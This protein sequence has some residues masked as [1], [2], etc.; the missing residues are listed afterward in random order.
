M[1]R[2]SARYLVC[3]VRLRLQTIAMYAY[4]CVSRHPNRVQRPVERLATAFFAG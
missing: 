2:M 1:F 3:H 4:T